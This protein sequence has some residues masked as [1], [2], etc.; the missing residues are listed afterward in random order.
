MEQPSAVQKRLTAFETALLAGAF[1]LFIVLL[2]MMEEFLSP[3]IVGMAG[4]ILLWPLRKYRTTRSLLYAGGFL[5]LV[6]FFVTASSVLIPFGAVFLIAYVFE[7]I[8]RNAKERFKVPRALTA[9]LLTSLVVGVV[10]AFALILVPNIVSQLESLGTRL[11]T[12]ANDLRAWVLTTPLL[13]QLEDA[14]V[15]EKTA[16]IDQLNTL[17]QNQAT[18]LTNGIP[19]AAEGLLKSFTSV[20]EVVTVATILPVLLF[21]MIKDYPAIERGIIGLFP[22]FDG[23]RDY[24]MKAGGI[25]GNYLRGLLTISAIAAFNV[26]VLLLIFDIPFAL[27]IGLLAGFLNMIPNL[28]A[29]ITMVLGVVIG[30]VFGDPWIAETLIIVGVLFGQSM[31]EGT[32]LTPNILSYQVGLHPALILFALFVFGFFMGMFGLLIAVPTTA[33]LITVY[34]AYREQV[35]FDLMGMAAP[36]SPTIMQRLRRRRAHKSG[37]GETLSNPTP[38]TDDA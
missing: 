35:N 22:T 6:W 29:L 34:K 7:P 12:A 27:L 30:V 26:T 21:Y 24:L 9:L 32:V 28:G 25:V 13:D 8:A 36:V 4:L 38:P 20:L 16:V 2:F 14:G 37:E 5:L 17:I 10:V 19:Q 23:K 18:A 11:L 33:L 31:L 1:A 15:I 3:F